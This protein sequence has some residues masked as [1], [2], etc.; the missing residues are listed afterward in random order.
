MSSQQQQQRDV[1]DK[2]AALAIGSP[3]RIPLILS[4]EEIEHGGV[5]A[6]QPWFSTDIVREPSVGTADGEIQDQIKGYTE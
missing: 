3:G 4:I 1:H 5:G 2:R 6:V